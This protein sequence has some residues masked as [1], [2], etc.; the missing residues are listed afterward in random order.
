LQPAHCFDN[1]GNPT[2]RLK[3]RRPVDINSGL[4]YNFFRF[5][6]LNIGKYTILETDFKNKYLLLLNNDAIFYCNQI[7]RQIITLYSNGLSSIEIALSINREYEADYSS[8]QI[9][10]FL[11]SIYRKSLVKNKSS[12]RK[13]IELL[14]TRKIPNYNISFL[15][16]Q[17]VFYGSLLLMF[18]IN[19]YCVNTLRLS[20]SM[21]YIETVIMFMVL[22]L[23][24]LF[25]EIGHSILA[26]LYEINSG[27]IGIGLYFI[28]PVFYININEI[29]R[30]KKDKRVIINLGG[31]YFQLLVGLI[32][33]I[34]YFLTYSP[35][36][37]SL[38]SVNIGVVIMNINP[39]LKFDGYW[40]LSDFI[41]DNQLYIKSSIAIKQW[42]KFKR[43]SYSKF[44]T[45]YAIGRLCFLIFVFYLIFLFTLNLIL[46]IWLLKT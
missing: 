8:E 16:N 46:K 35:V 10:S 20:R 39:F 17:Y 23:V 43:H 9:A 6:I 40:V 31:I 19:I 2:G 4:L 29:W 24:F 34:L 1:F 11:D 27:K 5:T 12:F 30:L 45:C 41:N 33:I 21:N 3:I 26:K 32:L 44:I 28:F 42:L 18:V 36:I 7:T 15:K 38:I 22:F 13:L 37:V 14:D 25:H